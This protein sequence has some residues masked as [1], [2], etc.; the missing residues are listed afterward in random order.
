MLK[1]R[2]AIL[3]EPN[4]PAFK[5]NAIEGL[6][7]GTVGKIY[8]EFTKPFWPNNWS[9]AAVLWIKSDLEELRNSQ[10]HRWLEDMIGFFTVVSQ[11]NVLLGWINGASARKMETLTDEEVTVGAMWMIRKCYKEFV[12]IPD[13]I[14][15]R[16]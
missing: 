13:P 1:E 10:N 4:L 2:H 15:V 8:L 9:G 5:I 6:E 12:N 16:R 7:F 3:F 11:P 14:H